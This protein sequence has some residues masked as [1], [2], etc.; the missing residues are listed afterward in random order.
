ML[1]NRAA[2]HPQLISYAFIFLVSSSSADRI[3]R[4]F[5]SRCMEEVVETGDVDE[6]PEVTPE[7]E[8]A[9]PKKNLLWRALGLLRVL[10]R[11][12]APARKVLNPFDAEVRASR[13]LRRAHGD[14]LRFD[15]D[16]SGTIERHELCEM[17]E[18]DRRG[19]AARMLMAYFDTNEDGEISFE[20]FVATLG[21]LGN[22]MERMRKGARLSK[23]SEAVCFI[24]VVMD[25]DGDGRVHRN[26]F[27]HILWEYEHSK[28]RSFGRLK[29]V[30]V[31]K[32]SEANSSL[33]VTA[34]EKYI[35]D[36]RAERREFLR[37]VRTFLKSATLY[38]SRQCPEYLTLEDMAKVIAEFEPLFVVMLTLHA[39]LKKL[40]KV[41]VKV[42][43]KMHD[44]IYDIENLHKRMI[45]QAVQSRIKREEAKGTWDWAK[46]LQRNNQKV[47]DNKEEE[48][49]ERQIA[50]EVAQISRLLRGEKVIKSGTEDESEF[51]SSF[52]FRRDGSFRRMESRRL[53]G[54]R[55]TGRGS[56][57][58]ENLKMRARQLSHQPPREAAMVLVEL[59]VTSQKDVIRRLSPDAAA[60]IIA[61]MGQLQQDVLLC[62]FKELQPLVLK[63]KKERGR[64]EDVYEF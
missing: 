9:Q 62:H 16:S 56:S 40:L 24:H 50:A 13:L 34:V 37:P 38:L 5:T 53:R 21:L 3:V 60:A 7:E 31:A 35:A 58:A 33:Q 22:S 10:A 51:L 6:E 44:G 1:L 20:E 49:E 27:A 61:E 63:I 12:C 42:V 28:S 2:P 14:F 64:T 29:R 46:R 57:G 11:R 55:A 15:V 32:F 47:L 52:S 59:G 19:Y 8:V 17:L 45:E 23:I 48:V 30:P 26:D 18:I 41:C 54:P 43:R 4:R 36:Q 25:S 39:K